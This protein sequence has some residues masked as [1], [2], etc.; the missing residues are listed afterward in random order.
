MPTTFLHFSDTHLG[1]GLRQR[2]SL[3]YTNH[4]SV[5]FQRNFDKVLNECYKSKIDF[6]LHTGDLFNRSKPH[7]ITRNAILQK[8]FELSQQKPVFIIPGNHD[9]SLIKGK[10][11]STLSKQLTIFNRPKT[12][13]IQ[14]NDKNISVS[15]IPFFNN[16]QRNFEKYMRHAKLDES[17][18]YTI[19]M[20][21][22][23]IE[24]SKHGIYDYTF[25]RENK[26]V[27]L[28][29]NLPDCNYIA[30]GHVHRFQQL[31]KNVVYAGSTERTSLIEREE[32]KGYVLAKIEE[33]KTEISFHPLETRPMVQLEVDFREYL[34]CKEDLKQKL[35]N[36]SSKDVI[37]CRVRFTDQNIETKTLYSLQTQL[38]KELDFSFL[39][40]YPVWQHP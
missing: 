12:A 3:K 28:L 6:V 8:L 17:C 13:R 33:T 4:R 9:K 15:G 25:T 11:F 18:D 7:I 27:I 40:I 30:L 37:H 26:E 38:K 39:K 19:L 24:K 29:D 16:A 32:V 10:L 14:I 34:E 20:L 1:L 36:H 2:S 23:L 22:Q 31:P 5:D 35:E 21:H